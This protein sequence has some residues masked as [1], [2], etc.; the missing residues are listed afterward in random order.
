MGIRQLFTLRIGILLR[1]T[2]IFV[3]F[4]G[5]TA[6]NGQTVKPASF[7]LGDSLVDP[8]NNNYI[9]TLAK[10]N[11]R[12][13]GL[14]FPQG[15]TGRFCNGR[16]TADFIVQMMGLP[17]PPPYLSKETQGPAILQGINYASAAAG[18]LDS[19]GFNYI[20]R[21]SLNKQLTYLENTKAQ[22]AQLIGEAKTGEVF[23]KSLWSVIIGS[24][25]YINNYLLT[26]SATSRQYTPQQYQDLLISEFKKQLRTL[27]GLGARKIVVFGVGP[28]G[29]IPSQLYNQRSP[30]GSCIQFVNS[31]VRGFNAASK[32]LLKQLT[33]SLP[34]SNFVYANVYDLIASYV[35][36]P[37]QFGKRSLPTFL[38]SSVVKHVMGFTEVNK[39]CCGGGPYNGLIPCLPTVRTCPDRAAYLFWDPF[40][41]T[42]KANGLL[43][44]EFFHGGK[45]VM[46]PINFQ[47]LFSMP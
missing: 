27:Y 7:I 6:S 32:I 43:A 34:G 38:R 40:H 31:Y 24:N 47:Q 33:A 35:S 41:P 37:A 20:G 21:I 4:S 5:I 29:C 23:A 22:F 3:V 15:P 10:S 19:T 18:I 25:D 16:T 46:D 26:G 28:L 8:G 12:P 11:F 17:F 45:D 44:R 30:D 14:D 9:L 13:N 2:M 39:G 42:D 36:S 1:L